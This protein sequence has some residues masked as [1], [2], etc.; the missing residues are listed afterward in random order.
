MCAQSRNLRVC[1]MPNENLKILAVGFCEEGAHR[2]GRESCASGDRHVVTLGEFNPA[3]LFERL[4]DA[5]FLNVEN[6]IVFPLR[7]LERAKLLV[8]D[9]RSLPAVRRIERATRF[10]IHH[11]Q[12][13]MLAPKS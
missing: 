1:I 4:P 2:L 13:M 8:A 9:S 12:R 7:E 5:L 11:G 6:L 3:G 10:I